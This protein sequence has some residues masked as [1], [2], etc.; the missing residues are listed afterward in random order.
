[1]KISIP[2]FL[3]CVALASSLGHAECVGRRPLTMQLKV[4]SC[5]DSYQ[6][7]VSNIDMRKYS[8][9]K[10]AELKISTDFVS[11]VDAQALSY[12]D[13]I[14]VNSKTGGGR[15]RGEVHAIAKEDAQRKMMLVGVPVQGCEK[16]YKGKTGL[17]SVEE[18][19]SC[20]RDVRTPDDVETT[21]QCLIK[22]PLVSAGN[23]DTLES[24]PHAKIK[25]LGK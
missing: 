2:F 19:F 16:Y 6:E 12:V 17:F 1:M 25:V 21:A 20:C 8:Q 3:A 7:A 15:Y 22:L 14:D 9:Q 24:L 18:E 11:V 23:G 5:S 13:T 4:L 10:M